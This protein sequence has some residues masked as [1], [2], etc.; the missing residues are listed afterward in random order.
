MDMNKWFLSIVAGLTLAGAVLIPSTALA[1]SVAGPCMPAGLGFSST[2]SPSVGSP[3]FHISTAGLSA[4]ADYFTFD[5]TTLSGTEVTVCAISPARQ[6]SVAMVTIT[7]FVKGQPMPS[8]LAFGSAQLSP[9]AFTID[10]QLTSA[11]L[12]APTIPMFDKISGAQFDVAVS[13]A[14]SGTGTAV[15][16]LSISH[17]IGQG[18]TF[19]GHSISDER[20]ANASGSV[21]SSTTIFATGSASLANL[22]S[23]RSGEVDIFRN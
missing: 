1:G 14:W 16:S 21:A 13:L 5:P 2:S 18:F 23:A 9:G 17:T 7:Q 10:R 20:A 22:D 15:H 3:V 19:I 11:V 6:P 4:G 12:N 8:L